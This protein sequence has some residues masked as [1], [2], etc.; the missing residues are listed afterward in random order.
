M[1][2]IGDEN[3][4]RKFFPLVT[5]VLLLAN[6]IVF[7]F[8][9]TRGEAF[10]ER[11][12]FVPAQFAADP[13]GN[14]RTLFSSLFL[15]AGL[16][17]LA[18]NM[19]YLLIFG[20]NIEHRFGFLPFILFYLLSGA[21]GN[22]THLAFS[23]GSSTPVIGASGA[24]AGV[25][26]AYILLYPKQPVRVLMFITIIR[27]PAVVVIGAWFILQLMSSLAMFSGASDTGGIAYLAHVGGF[28]AGFFMT[29][30]FR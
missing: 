18:S 10:I 12:A 25:L 28:V 30:L 3:R 5:I 14:W 23:A 17:H 2:P 7:Y 4:T 22:L 24:I 26:G 27:L 9:V 29:F 6:V 16:L 8:E 13:I 15:H 19:I 21:F 1:F 20:D 11:W